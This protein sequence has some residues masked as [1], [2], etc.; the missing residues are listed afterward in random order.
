MKKLPHLIS[1]N[2]SYLK[3]ARS[4]FKYFLKLSYAA[5][6][7]LLHMI[8]PQWHQNTASNIAKEIVK[9][10]SIRHKK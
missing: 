2:E 3:H 4:A 8:Y 6:A 10:V 7:V 1:A 5:L 9:D